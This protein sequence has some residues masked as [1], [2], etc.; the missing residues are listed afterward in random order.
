MTCAVPAVS[1]TFWR[2]SAPVRGAGHAP[3]CGAPSQRR[4]LALTCAASWQAFTGDAVRSYAGLVEGVVRRYFA[5]WDVG[6]EV[7]AYQQCKDLA[8]DVAC[9]ILLGMQ[10]DV[11]CH[12]HARPTLHPAVRCYHPV[13][14]LRCQAWRIC[15]ARH[16]RLGM[17]LFHSLSPV[18]CHLFVVCSRQEFCLRNTFVA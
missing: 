4:C 3:W 11:R 13:V 1:G 2:R 10:L 9:A 5:R 17:A 7:K 12:L 8:F 15:G 18:T 16:V 14:L 6:G